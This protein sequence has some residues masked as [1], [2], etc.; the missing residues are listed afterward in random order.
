M[1]DIIFDYI[2]EEKTRQFEHL[3]L[4]ASENFASPAVREEGVHF[5]Q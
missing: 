1:K 4:I 3:E 2:E 5:N